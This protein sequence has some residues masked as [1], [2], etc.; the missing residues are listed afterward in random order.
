MVVARG[1]HQPPNYADPRLVNAP[2][3]HFFDVMTNGYGA[4][5]SYASR[6]AVDDRWRIAA[7]IRTL[8][9]SQNAPAALAQQGMNQE[10]SNMKRENAV[11]AGG[12]R[13]GGM[14]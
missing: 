5:Y 9:M 11:A 14:K 8:Q 1:L 6:V 12:G 4:M 3:G 7:Y 2:V 10:P 13:A